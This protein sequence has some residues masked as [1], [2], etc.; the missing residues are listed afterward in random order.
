MRARRGLARGFMW[1][2]A[3]KEKFRPGDPP[4]ETSRSHT[5]I[6]S[7][8]SWESRKHQKPVVESTAEGTLDLLLKPPPPKELPCSIKTGKP[9]LTPASQGSHADFPLCL[10]PHRAPASC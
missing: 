6:P 3:T 7:L 1:E 9:L 2:H 8:S 5:V 4:P 10:V